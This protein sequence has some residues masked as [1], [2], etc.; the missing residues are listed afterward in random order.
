MD[1]TCFK[2]FSSCSVSLENYFRLSSTANLG[3]V[4]KC[5]V[6]GGVLKANL[7][8]SRQNWSLFCFLKLVYR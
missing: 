4:L 6:G 2:P 3:K 5:L 7:I 1:K 8:F